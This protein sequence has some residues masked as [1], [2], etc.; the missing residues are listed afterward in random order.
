[1]NFQPPVL[2]NTVLLFINYPVHNLHYNSYL[3]APSAFPPCPTFTLLA[4]AKQR[5][6][7]LEDTAWHFL[8]PSLHSH[9]TQSV[10]FIPIPT[11]HHFTNLSC[12]PSLPPWLTHRPYFFPPSP[13]ALLWGTRFF[14][15]H[16]KEEFKST[17]LTLTTLVLDSGFQAL[18]PRFKHNFPTHASNETFLKSCHFS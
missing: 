4:L 13:C 9:S 5:S 6:Y 10:L 3:L 15:N 17:A 14:N 12:V 7:F 16:S 18:T 1:M 2:S 11:S 8:T